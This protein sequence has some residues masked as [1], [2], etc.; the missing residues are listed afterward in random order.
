MMGEFEMLAVGEATARLY[1]A[2]DVR[3]GTPGVVVLHPWWGLNDDVIAYADRLA[4]A[5]FAVTAPDMFNGQVASTIEDAERLSSSAENGDAE[6]SVESIALA[7]VDDL[8][9]RLGPTSRLGVLGFSFGAAYA[10]LI[11]AERDRLVAS[12][13]YYGVYTGPHIGQSTAALLGQFAETDQFESDEGIAELEDSVRAAGREV[14][15]HR[16][17]GTGHWFAEPSR[18]A[19]RPEAADLAFERTVDFLREQLGAG[20]SPG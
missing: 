19:Y 16:Y 6:P 2:G 20:P 18:D 14:T 9:E 10:L 5:G 13:V 1:V 15:I 4:A 17:P 11:P 8:A 12:V 7:A 3:P